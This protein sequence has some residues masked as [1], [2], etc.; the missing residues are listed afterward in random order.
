MSQENAFMRVKYRKVI[1]NILR[2]LHPKE[3]MAESFTVRGFG[4]NLIELVGIML[5]SMQAFCSI[6]GIKEQTVMPSS[7][8][9]EFGKKFGKEELQKLYDY[10]RTYGVPPHTVDAL[11]LALYSKDKRSFS[12]TSKTLLLQNTKKAATLIQPEWKIKPKRVKK[13]K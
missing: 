10:A 5:G 13:S 8:K 9:G 1:H 7:W 3:L 12:N 2:K 4:T 11:C 6:L